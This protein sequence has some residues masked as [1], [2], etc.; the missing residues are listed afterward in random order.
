MR[1]PL[2]V[3]LAATLCV[4]AVPLVPA[5]G[6]PGEELVACRAR[7]EDG[8]KPVEVRKDRWVR[9]NGPRMNSGEGPRQITDFTTMPGK[10]NVVVVTNGTVLK[11]S[12]DAGCT[13]SMLWPGNHVPSP[14]N[15][16]V[17]YLPDTFNHLVAPSPATVWVTSYDTV[18]GLPHPH[19]YAGTGVADD[20]K[21]PLFQQYDVGLPQYGTP[22]AVT[23]GSFALSEAFVLID[24][25]PDPASGAAMTPTRRLYS[26]AVPATPPQAAT[27]APLAWDEVTLPDGL[28]H[29]EG[30]ARQGIRNLWLWSGRTVAVGTDVGTDKESWNTGTAAGEVATIDIGPG[31]T[32]SV[33]SKTQQGTVREIADA[34]AH[35]KPAGAVPVLPVS[36]AHGENL[37][38]FAASG[39]EG[40]WGFDNV[41]LRWVNITP[42]G[43]APFPRLELAQG[44]STR[45]VVG[46][47]ADHLWRWDTYNGETFLKPPPGPRSTGGIPP[48]PTSTLRGAV[49]TP[50]HEVV[51]IPPGPVS[52]VPVTFRVPPAP[53][54]LDVYFLIDTTLSMGP[55]IRGLQDAV[56][57]ISHDIQNK[58]GIQACFGLG[59]FKDLSADSAYVYRV[60]QKVSECKD[61]PKLTRLTER[62][63]SLT[64][65]GGGSPPEAQ[66][67]A[68]EQAVLG[69]G[70]TAPLVLPDQDAGFRDKSYKVI[71]LISDASFN[72]GAGYPSVGE[73]ADIMKGD[74]IKVVSIAVKGAVDPGG[75]KRSMTELALATK[76]LAPAGGVDCNGDGPAMYYGDLAPGDPLVCEVAITNGDS[77]TGAPVVNIG[78]A[79]L[80]LLLAVK[81]PGTLEVLV[82]D[83]HKV[84]A[85]PIKGKTSGEFD[86]KYE[87]G[88]G[89]TLPVRCSAAQDGKDLTVGLL[90]TVRS[91]SVGLYGE[92]VVRCRKAPVI[93]PPPPPPP[94]VE[95]PQVTVVQPPRPPSAVVV[96]PPLNPPVQPI[97]NANPN[98]G[99]SS[100]EE[101][102][103][104]L[105]TV[106]QDASEEEQTAPETEYA[107][108]G[109]ERASREGAMA[110][111]F[112]GA[113]LL[114][115]ATAFAL[116]RRAQ[117]AV[118]TVRLR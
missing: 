63:R 14:D 55:A 7:E 15:G 72:S 85:P 117:H 59:D 44:T 46:H 93:P 49:L 30:M 64:D 41:K 100:Q 102:Q 24:E 118:R 27:V 78:P 50:E 110:V 29:V 22:V 5:S 45:Y 51:T 20:D 104:Q 11:I 96:V 25:L 42:K 114:S 107:M 75:A 12:A 17:A 76:S 81:D 97:S 8:S 105:A 116:R 19:V 108:S 79:I 94:V 83:P 101:Q 62:I 99:F 86:L 6:S 40:T 84:V 26:A 98:A 61:D 31:P 32:V 77:G 69:N 52:N 18:G 106:G 16:E 66:T 3:L 90:P 68:L 4:L 74:E 89:F 2:R 58:I 70:R 111:T 87:S 67:V 71:V 34:Q 35:L 60:D 103:F 23:A 113:A 10:S 13:W 56:I 95:D 92:V 91:A 80:S 57:G 73:V 43:V 9:I 1:R 112:A 28:G 82:D 115:T 53:T 48:I 33:V 109:L 37:D 38:T 39:A 47:D 36:F 65:A 88:L 21:E 54:P